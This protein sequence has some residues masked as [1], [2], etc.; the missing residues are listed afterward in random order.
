MT[1]LLVI[2]EFNLNFGIQL[3]VPFAQAKSNSN[4]SNAQSLVAQAQKLYENGNYTLAVEIL[5][6]AIEAFQASGDQLEQAMALSNLAL[7]VKQLG[8]I[9][10]SYSYITKSLEILKI[11]RNPQL[12]AQSLEIQGNLLLELGKTQEASD[13]WQ[14]AA[15]IYTQLGDEVGKIRSL[16]N[17]AQAEQTLGLYLQARTNLQEVVKSVDK[18]PDSVMKIT[19]LRSLGDVLQLVGE[20]HDS[21]KYLQQ[22]RNLAQKLRSPEQ[23]AE[24]LLSLGNIQRGFGNSASNQKNAINGERPTPLRYITSNLNNP[25]SS[26]ASKYYQQAVQ[27]YE[28]AA[29][30]YN[31]PVVQ[32][33]AKLNQLSVL[34]EMH[35]W[36]QAQQL[37]TDIQSRLN[38]VPINQ[39]AIFARINLAQSLVHLKQATNVDILTWEEIA[40]GLATAIKQA[41]S[42]GDQRSEAYALGALGGVYLETKDF[43]NAQKLT[44]QGLKIALSMRMG[45]I[46]YLWQWQLG[47]IFKMRDNI[48]SAIA[49]YND[50]YD[51]LISLRKDLVALNPDVQFSFRDNVEPVYRQFV[52]LLLQP[53]DQSRK[54]SKE[55]LQQ[56]RTVIEALQFTE[57]ENF[58]R[59]ACLE[60]SSKNIDDVVDKTDSKTA[61]IYPIL[62]KDRLEIILKLP[63]KSELEHYT[64]YKRANEVEKNLEELQRSLAEPDETK[65][66]KKY[67]QEVYNW[68]IKPRE[69]KLVEMNIKT[70]VFVL[71]G[72]LRNIPMAVLY[73]QQEKKFLIEKYAIA[74]APGLQLVDPKPLQRRKIYALTAGVSQK[75]KFGDRSFAPLKNVEVE[76]RDIQSAIPKHKRLL[77]R[78][79]TE[80]N[81]RSQIKEASY[82]VVHIATHG[83]FSSN[84]EKTFILTWDQLLKV[85]DFDQLLRLGNSSKSRAIELLVL[86]A[87]QT[88]VG[89]KRATLGLAGIAVRAGTR[90]TLATLWSVDDGST[91]KLM[92]KFYQ[93]LEDPKLTK[94]E[95]LQRA[96]LD[97]LNKHKIPY[98]WA[99]YILVGNWL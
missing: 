52:D 80:E 4:Q 13:T 32:V 77:N 70:L 86:S 26:E 38:Q 84:A 68:L 49:S 72:S 90:S 16:I 9:Q 12:L 67:S 27:F 5:Q 64:V 24:T 60:P 15:K 57:L 11:N 42:I 19:L 93:E 56:A 2:F 69:N 8:Q 54:I 31:S 65:D 59:Q 75:R 7:V 3:A 85:K 76:L 50:A 74:L 62:L 79:F 66:V 78:N 6:Q 25:I 45:D 46:A 17:L 53:Q 81:V 10:T 33:Q 89:D 29:T 88:A 47:Y 30:V 40:Q 28:Q 37:Y 92:I 87:C 14:Q 95:A 61:V 98:L 71:D 94:A 48:P 22:S 39:T 58:F 41:R 96:Q 35:N 73:D 99:P 43:A 34:L 97:L 55:N 63:N 20:L 36:S 1:A 82:N 44:D 23:L 21:E 18:Q 51:T 83:E 91:A